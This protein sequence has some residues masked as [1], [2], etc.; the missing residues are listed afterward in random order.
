MNPDPRQVDLFGNTPD[1]DGA[2]YDHK[3]DYVRLSGA[4]SRVYGALT[5]GHWHTLKSL[6]A[7][8]HC[9]EAAAS[10]RIRDLRKPKFGAFLIERRYI[11]NGL[12]EYRMQRGKSEFARNSSE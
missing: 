3:R 1:F 2:T 6:A 10:A 4:L 5:T 8:A 7:L 9:S 11:G 12:H